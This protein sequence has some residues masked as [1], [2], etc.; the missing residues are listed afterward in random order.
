MCPLPYLYPLAQVAG[1]RDNYGK[2]SD[3]D[4]HYVGM[5]A[6]ELAVLCVGLGSGSGLGLVMCVA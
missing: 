5:I 4:Q 1:K 3:I 2:F 6:S